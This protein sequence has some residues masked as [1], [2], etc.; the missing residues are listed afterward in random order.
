MK[1]YIIKER[2]EKITFILYG[3]EGARMVSYFGGE[4]VNWAEVEAG[5]KKLEK[6]NAVGKEV[7]T[8]ETIKNEPS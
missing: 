7:V 6:V 5:M 4:P 1:I 8:K 2:K 3:L